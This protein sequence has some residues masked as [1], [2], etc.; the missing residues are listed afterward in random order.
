MVPRPSPDNHQ[1][2]DSAWSES[3]ATIRQ[4]QED[5][6]RVVTSELLQGVTSDLKNGVVD[7]KGLR[8]DA[9]GD[10]LLYAPV[11]QVTTSLRQRVKVSYCAPC[12]QPLHPTG[13]NSRLAGLAVH[14][15]HM[16][17][18]LV[19]EHPHICEADELG[20]ILETRALANAQSYAF[21]RWPVATARRLDT[22]TPRRRSDL[23]RWPW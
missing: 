22:S 21:K 4:A 12:K 5:I 15:W 1:P 11:V 13:T 14:P 18:I 7:W 9:F 6:A 17:G 16:P 3:L 8:P 2:G 20:A 23:I 19:R 10:I